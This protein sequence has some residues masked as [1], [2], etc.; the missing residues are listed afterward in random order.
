MLGFF[1]FPEKGGEQYV[2]ETL[3]KKATEDLDNLILVTLYDH[4][5]LT[6][7]QICIICGYDVEQ[8]FRQKINR[9]L[10]VLIEIGLV[11]RRRLAQIGIVGN[12]IYMYYLTENGVE[13]SVTL[14][15]IPFNRYG[16]NN[17]IIEKNHLEA[18]ELMISD[19]LLPHHFHTQNWIVE[20]IQ[21]FRSIYG[22]EK[23]AS[24][25]ILFKEPKRVPN[26]VN[27]LGQVT[28]R[29]DWIIRIGRTNVTINLELDMGTENLK[30]LTTKF[31]N[32]AEWFKD[33]P[34]SGNHVI[35][36]TSHTEKNI[37]RRRH[38]KN[39]AIEYLG[40]FIREGRLE[41]CEGSIPITSGWMMS[42]LSRL[43]DPLERDIFSETLKMT[44]DPNSSGLTAEYTYL[45]ACMKL[46]K[47]IPHCDKVHFLYRKNA[48]SKHKVI[49]QLKVEPGSCLSEIQSR[50]LCLL[51]SSMNNAEYK[52]YVYVIHDSHEKRLNDIPA[53]QTF[54]NIYSVDVQTLSQKG[55]KH[56]WIWSE[57]K[58][59]W[60]RIEVD[61]L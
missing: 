21:S 14:L 2:A 47:E 39:L 56:S 45:E 29:P 15:E 18:K 6:L 26:Y 24:L 49:F 3:T 22:Q 55:L 50:D 61:L 38:I 5:H 37:T 19:R 54:N 42:N 31:R 30:K 1:A 9:R 8:K 52:G 32:Y 57:S 41:V 35:L 25:G 10:K 40:E 59:K 27:K 4:R 53:L 34:Q 12:P 48:N 58:R 7:P 46:G 60:Q 36:F 23:F 11:K 44:Y 43:I 51:A 28:H 20:F 33:N 16:Q 13:R 17:K